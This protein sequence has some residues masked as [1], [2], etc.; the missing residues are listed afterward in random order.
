MADSVKELP[1][2]I[3]WF[4]ELL[5]KQLEH[6]NI[7]HLLS[8]SKDNDFE[9]LSLCFED[10]KQSAFNENVHEMDIVKACVNLGVRSYLMAYKASLRYHK[11][12]EEIKIR[13]GSEHGEYD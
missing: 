4:A 11:K 10:V 2:P 1:D 12:M 13:D 5:Q 9:L 3:V 8:S 6:K 7:A